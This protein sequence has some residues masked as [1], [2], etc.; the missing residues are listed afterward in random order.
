MTIE[1]QRLSEMLH[2]LTPEPPRPVTVEDVAIRLA[3]QAAPQGR[4]RRRGATQRGATQRGNGI[5]G[6]DGH[7]AVLHRPEGPRRQRPRW[8]PVLAAA[9]VVA[10]VGGSA[11]V[12]VT[13]TSHSKPSAPAGGSLTHSA[14]ATT[15]AGTNP[16]SPASS[17][18][19]ST[20]PPEP[21][22]PVAGG[23]WG[24]VLIN[25]ETL[26]PDTLVGGGTFLY[27]IANGYLLK[28]DPASGDVMQQ[29]P[30]QFNG[31]QSNRPVLVGNTVWVV[32][33]ADGSGITLHGF[34]A[35]TLAPEG[36]VSVSGG[37][38]T[39]GEG[40][41]AG[42][43]GGTDLYVAAGNAV[44]VV[45]PSSNSVI[46]RI[47]VP[48]TVTSVAV[49]PD[50]S[51]VYAG[52]TVGGSF[53]LGSYDASTGAQ[54]SMSSTQGN[55][56]GYLVATGGGVWFTTGTQMVQRAWF[57]PGGD[58]S[59]ARMITGGEDGGLDSVPTYANGVVWVGGTRSLQCLNPSTGRTLASVTIPADGGVPEHF[60]S[61]A[62]ASGHIYAN[63]QDLHSQLEGIA[64]VT[65]PSACAG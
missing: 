6:G 15:P 19:T 25:H 35:L 64:A 26:Q 16:T 7:T 34:N 60:G 42:N 58:L 49:S 2:R 12:G 30:V 40:L 5:G 24:A 36:N 20:H 18:P 44:A 4:A 3:N 39:G 63:Y 10:V 23:L 57:A 8:A 9:A 65:P 37:A 45:D 29:V 41:V 50:G 55:A 51:V 1:E 14:G 48:G 61:V 22:I 59:N 54:R 47:S 53:H 62:F 28:F 31:P 32:W 33:S 27:A 52:F 56:T 38:P 46:K 43:Q 13:L 17:I 11:A 21:R